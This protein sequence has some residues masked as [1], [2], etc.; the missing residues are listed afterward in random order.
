V[1]VLNFVVVKVRTAIRIWDLTVSRPLEVVSSQLA[2]S[3]HH[4][5]N[6]L[7][8]TVNEMSPDGDKTTRAPVFATSVGRVAMPTSGFDLQ[9]W[10]PIIG[11][12][13]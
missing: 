5:E 9:H 6:S 1:T 8:A 10:F 3:P 2:V 12:P 4:Y 11:R 13:L 7:N